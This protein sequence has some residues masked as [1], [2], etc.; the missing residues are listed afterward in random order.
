MSDG[1]KSVAEG[2]PT[3]RKVIRGMPGPG[4]LVVQWRVKSAAP[5]LCHRDVTWTRFALV[6]RKDARRMV[7]AMNREVPVFEFRLKPPTQERPK[8]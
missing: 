3:F 8:R 4:K 1:L 7:A 2:P 6:P 5:F